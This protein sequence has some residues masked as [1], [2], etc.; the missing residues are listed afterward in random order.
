MEFL[1]ALFGDK[2][3]TYEEMAQ[4]INDHNEANKD[5]QIKVGNLG[6]GEYV[7]KAKHDALQ[8]L[9]DGKTTELD[10]ANALIAELKQGTQEMEEIQSKITGY[11]TQ[12]TELQRELAETKVKATLQVA[13]M[14]EKATDVDY[15]T[16]KLE[17]KLKEEG[18][19]LEVDENENIK[20]LDDLMSGLKT[21]FPTHFEKA[22]SNNKVDVFD[23][24]KG[25]QQKTMTKEE[26]DKL[27]Y[28]SRVELR[29]ENPELYANMTK[30]R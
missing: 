18:K 6:S 1:K 11:E 29:K 5:K 8:T 23:L 4:A 7:G 24:Q 2:A 27:G 19:T 20:G 22:N 16:Y 26:F 13:L 12:V 17:E 21:Q 28:N 14:A 9:L 30:G 3:L 15:L 25:E 10:T